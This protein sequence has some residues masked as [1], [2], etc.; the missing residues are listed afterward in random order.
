MA[1]DLERRDQVVAYARQCWIGWAFFFPWDYPT[2]RPLSHWR[3]ISGVLAL[4]ITHV[5]C[6][7]LPLMPPQT[8]TVKRF[9]STAT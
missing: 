5:K 9:G 7:K 8:V 4:K 1:P 3:R 2:V 6:L